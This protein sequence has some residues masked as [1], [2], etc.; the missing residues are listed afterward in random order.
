MK[1]KFISARK[2][3]NLNKRIKK[4]DQKIVKCKQGN[5]LS[6]WDKKSCCHIQIIYGA[7]MQANEIKTF[8]EAK[9]IVAILTT[10]K[11]R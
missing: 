9:K 8:T 6:I 11:I 7:T 1:S 10:K 3:Q 2:N 5:L 4:L